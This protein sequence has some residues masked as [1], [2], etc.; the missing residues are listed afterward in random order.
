VYALL[1]PFV[2]LAVLAWMGARA[3]FRA[4]LKE[5]ASQHP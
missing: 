2:G 4:V 1:F 3:L 5:S